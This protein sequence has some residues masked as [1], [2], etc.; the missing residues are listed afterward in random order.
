MGCLNLID[1]KHFFYL[2][3]MLFGMIPLASANVAW[4][5]NADYSQATGANGNE[6]TATNF[7]QYNFGVGASLIK[8]NSASGTFSGYYQT[9]VNGHSLNGV[10]INLSDLKTDGAA[11]N[12]AGFELTLTAQ[13]SGTYTQTTQFGATTTTLNNLVG[14][15]N[16]YFD[17]TPDFNFSTDSGFGTDTDVVG[18]TSILSG[19]ISGGG[20]TFSNTFGIGGESMAFDLSGVL[21]GYD[22]AVFSPDTINGG[23]VSFLLHLN[24]LN[25]SVISQVVNGNGTVM[26]AAYNQATD[27]LVE[28]NGTLELTTVPLP[29]G[30]WLLGSGLIALFSFGKRSF[31]TA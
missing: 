25:T 19:S 22:Q 24:P 29:A 11:G 12:G 4:V 14:S 2:I 8:L 23:N 1:K 17:S 5:G 15:T 30:I 9:M 7:S 27:I 3:V 6:S 28:G 21:D 13:Y 18:N 26:G 20:G 31:L 16:L 10:G